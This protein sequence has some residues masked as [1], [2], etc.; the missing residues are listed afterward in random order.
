MTEQ[1]LKI[2]NTRIGDCILAKEHVELNLEY[3]GLVEIPKEVSGLTNVTRIY[4]SGN[5]ISSIKPSDIP[6]SCKY[7][8]LKNNKFTHFDNNNLPH[9]V[10]TLD[11]SYNLLTDFDGSEMINLLQ[12]VLDNNQINILKCPPNICLIE[13]CHN[14]IEEIDDFPQS[15]KT[16]NLLDNKISDLPKMNHGL[17]FINV[18]HNCIWDMPLFPNNV[19][20][21]C[22]S[23]C[24]I[25]N[26][27][28]RLPAQLQVFKA[29]ASKIDKI[30]VELP[31][32]LDDL[33]LSDNNLKI[34][35]I[36]PSDL[37]HVD[38]SHNSIISLKDIP[39]S[40]NYLDISYNMLSTIDHDL[41]IRE[42]FKLDYE[43]N[44][45][46]NDDNV[47]EI[48]D[49]SDNS[50]GMTGGMPNFWD[51]ID[52]TPKYS[53]TNYQFGA[54]RLSRNT[55]YDNIDLPP[56]YD[57]VSDNNYTITNHNGISYSGA[58]YRMS[59]TKPTWNWQQNK[60]ESDFTSNRARKTNPHF[61]SM[62]FAD[63]HVVV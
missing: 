10:T 15:L 31:D 20:T 45:I 63:D 52:E 9:S 53:G 17:Q 51:G 36:L 55:G 6:S 50:C 26:I 1:S 14:N 30:S 13:A 54:N 8:S 33:D 29:Y 38:L 47:S 35:P 32:I 56:K 61:V 39:E 60:T 28:K 23:H 41:L 57:D 34:C 48:S 58:N 40:V 62:L 46:D 3:L 21:L 25:K 43:N 42:N 11:M 27:D 2:V 59:N 49:M 4:L 19:R 18:S 5:N 7:L 22:M 24:Y 44:F 16:I 12:V 37:H